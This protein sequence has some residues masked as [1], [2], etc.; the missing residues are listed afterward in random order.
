MMMNVHR[1]NSFALPAR[2]VAWLVVCLSLFV[3]RDVV[4]HDCYEL[5]RN[6][7]VELQAWVGQQT[8]AGEKRKT[9]SF[10]VNEQVILTIEVATPRWFTGGTRIGSIEMPNVI[11]KQRN[12]LATNLPEHK[13]GQTW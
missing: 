4:A 9:P 5:Q 3:S 7:G 13:G 6:H 12:Q 1:V 8:T 10:S 11:A 2:I